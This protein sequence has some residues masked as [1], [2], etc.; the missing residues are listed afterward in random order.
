[1]GLVKLG[2]RGR[3]LDNATRDLGSGEAVRPP[4]ARTLP[5]EFAFGCATSS[6]RN[7][8]NQGGSIIV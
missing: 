1:M 7:R 2:D 8:N 6:N 3:R 4:A 5:R